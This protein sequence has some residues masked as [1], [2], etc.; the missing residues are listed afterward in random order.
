MMTGA[1]IGVTVLLA[2]VYF[3]L[4]Y[5]QAHRRR[6]ELARKIQERQGRAAGKDVL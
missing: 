5:H 1:A 4:P 3:V 2:G 6:K